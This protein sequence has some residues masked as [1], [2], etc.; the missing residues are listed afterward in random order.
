MKMP[1]SGKSEVY[2]DYAATT[3]VD[4]RVKAE[5]EKFF[6]QEFANPG[7]MHAMGLSAK[8]ALDRARHAVMGIVGAEHESEVIFT[9]SG[10][11]SINLAVKGTARAMK[12]K[13]MHIITSTIEHH[14]VLDSCEYLEKHEGFEVTKIG[15]DR[16]GIINMDELERSI[17][18]DTVLITV[19]YANN[20]IGS[21]QPVREIAKI[22]KRK[23]AVFHTDACQAGGALDINAK[24]LGV[25]MMTLNGSKVYGPKGTGMLYVKKGTKIHSTIHGGGQEFGMRS[26]TE[27]VPG[28]TGFAKALVLAQKEKE[29]ENKRLSGLRDLFIKNALE[30]IPKSMLNGH[31]TQRLP[32]NVNI[33]ILDIEGEAVLLKLNELGALARHNLAWPPLRGRTREPA[34]Y[35]RKGNRKKGH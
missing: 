8:A 20:E 25:D 11:E 9:G 21:I 5:M 33:S 29:K 2:M 16:N 10:T 22:A 4:T 1:K 18:Q 12:G 24:E 6:S 27:N 28:I 32:N 31:P 26:G 30:K 15:V 14:A 23:G 34:L 13:G 35:S 7:S 3:P 17:R 19:M